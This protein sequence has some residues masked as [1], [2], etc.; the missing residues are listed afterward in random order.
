M[1]RDLANE[2]EK[3][4]RSSNAYVKKKVIIHCSIHSIIDS[5][6]FCF[7][8]LQAIL[9]AVRIVRKVPEQIDIYQNSVRNLL[10]DKN[11]GLSL[12]LN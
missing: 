2:V 11:H 8:S 5:L 4:M 10:T 9:C 7:I 6:R 12:S 3:L 1:S